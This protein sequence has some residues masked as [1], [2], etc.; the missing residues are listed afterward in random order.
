M[1]NLQNNY[2]GGER[3]QT[4]Q[5]ACYMKMQNTYRD[6][7]VVALGRGMEWEEDDSW[8]GSHMAAISQ[9]NE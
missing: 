4:K 6:R 1:D 2:A 9:Q 7:S 3:G 8:G 5:S